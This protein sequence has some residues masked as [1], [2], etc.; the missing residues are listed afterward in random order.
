MS[1]A[2]CCCI[3]TPGH[4]CG[5][6]CSGAPMLATACCCCILAGPEHAQQCRGPARAGQGLAARNGP[7]E[8]CCVCMPHL[9]AAI[10]GVRLRQPLV[11]ASLSSLAGLQRPLACCL[12]LGLLAS[13][14][15]ALQQDRHRCLRHARKVAHAGSAPW[16]VLSGCHAPGRADTARVHGQTGVALRWWQGPARPQQAG[17]LVPG[18]Q[19]CC[20]AREG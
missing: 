19:R 9:P 12:L 17:A 7:S 2:S 13:R 10:A 5:A 8:G 16:T 14:C 15:G 1:A 3:S 11:H 20:K 4:G 6:A 18:R